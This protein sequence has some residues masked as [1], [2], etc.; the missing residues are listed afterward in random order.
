MKL[1]CLLAVLLCGSLAEASCGTRPSGARIVGGEEAVPNSW[2]W[3]LSLRG[4]YSHKCGAT[5]ITPEWAVTA[6]H[7][8]GAAADP[9][10]LRLVAGAHNIRND[11]KEL[12]VARVIRHEKY[13]RLRHDI[14]LLRLARP[15]A[16][17]KKVSTACLPQQGDRA[18]PGLKCY[19]T[20]WGRY[21]STITNP[22]KSLRQS[23]VP[24]VDHV[25]C[26]RGLKEFYLDEETMMCVGGAGS[27]ACN[28]DSGGPLV[29]EEGGKWV[30]RGV[31][32]W[33]ATSQ[34][35]VNNYSVYARV[36]S[37]VDWI[38]DKIAADPG[39]DGFTTP[40]P[41]ECKDQTP[42]CPSWVSLC[43]VPAYQGFCPKTCGVCK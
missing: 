19:I 43:H 20:G 12:Y 32:S 21:H 22:A 34:C 30:L 13:K 39:V 7:C 4:P 29:C 31:A 14:A 3:Q 18:N 28:G 6:A 9:A 17:D 27:S 1:L 40:T 41:P 16:V 8:V 15:L 23:L 26:K 37:D 36:S 33:V 5:L 24:L 10:R 38:Q 25:T 11:G 2:P 42:N 35:P